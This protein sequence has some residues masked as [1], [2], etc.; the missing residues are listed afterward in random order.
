MENE[1]DIISTL[2]KEQ[3]ESLINNLVEAMR[4]F[5]KS[6]ATRV[7][8]EKIQKIKDA[9]SIQNVKTNETTRI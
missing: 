6:V 4:I 7:I 1:S 9:S 5:H 3:L 8:K 2:E